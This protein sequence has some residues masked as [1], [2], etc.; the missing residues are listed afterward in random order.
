MQEHLLNLSTTTGL[1]YHFHFSVCNADLIQQQER[2]RVCTS[3]A[4]PLAKCHAVK[5]YATGAFAE[6]EL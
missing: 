4:E 5:M 6:T 2:G 1:G 3:S